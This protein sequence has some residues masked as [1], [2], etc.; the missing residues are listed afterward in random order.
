MI[1]KAGDVV[2]INPRF[3]EAYIANAR[4]LCPDPS[5]RFGDQEDGHI[6]VERVEHHWEQ[7][8]IFIDTGGC[9]R[10]NQNGHPTDFSRLDFHE[11]LFI[12]INSAPKLPEPPESSPWYDLAEILLN[13]R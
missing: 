5:P 13:D 9:Y 4:K 12:P 6:H 2:D 11:P 8:D 1:P 10:I 3:K 7:F